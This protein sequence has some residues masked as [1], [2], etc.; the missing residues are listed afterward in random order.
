MHFVLRSKD[1]SSIYSEVWTK[2]L[3]LKEWCKIGIT[4]RLISSWV[5]VATACIC[6]LCYN[7]L[8]LPL[9]GSGVPKFSIRTDRSSAPSSRAIQSFSDKSNASTEIL[10]SPNLKALTFNELKNSTRN[11]HPDSFLGEGGFGYVFKGWI[12]EYNF[13]ATKPG[14]GMAV[15]VKKLNSER[16]Q[17]HKKW[18]VGLFLLFSS[19]F[20]GGGLLGGLYSSMQSYYSWR[21]YWYSLKF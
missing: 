17:G 10:S 8:F 12:D 14:S 4:L 7:E 6:C 15:A 3:L 9:P 2:I 5:E 13:S 1:V 21:N 18:L 20:R 16:F 19:F 11:F